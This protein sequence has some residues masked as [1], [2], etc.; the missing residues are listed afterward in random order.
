MT[1]AT[2]EQGHTNFLGIKVE[3]DII[4]R[5]KSAAQRPLSD[6][7]PLLRAVIDDPT[8]VEIGWEQYTPYF[9]DGEP[10]VFTVYGAWVRTDADPAPDEDAD[11]DTEG[12]SV[13]WGHPSLGKFEYEYTGAGRNRQRQVRSYEG[14]DEARLQR[15]LELHEALDSGAFND[16]LLDAFG[17]HASVK[18]RRDGITV[19]FVSHD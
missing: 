13:E 4:H 14:P 19:D 16:V 8:I 6:L 2:E 18:V 7:E 12:L 3:G 15:C 17:D 11:D 5:E 10:C 9:N 1:T